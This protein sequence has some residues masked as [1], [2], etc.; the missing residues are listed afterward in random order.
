MTKQEKWYKRAGILWR[1]KGMVNPVYLNR[2]EGVLTEVE[3]EK[4]N[5]AFKIIDEVLDSFTK[6]SIEL[7]FD[8]KPR[9]TICGRPA[10]EGSNYCRRCT[11]IV[12]EIHGNSS[13][14]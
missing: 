13:G 3:K 10:L 7:G 8:A 5:N 11:K 12:I 4:L 14:F 1:L 6:S 2:N 9:C